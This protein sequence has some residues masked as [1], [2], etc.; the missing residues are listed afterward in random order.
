MLRILC[1]ASIAFFMT[2]TTLFADDP[3]E[4]DGINEGP[5]YIAPDIFARHI[6]AEFDSLY[7]ETRIPEQQHLLRENLIGALRN[8]YEDSPSQTIADLIS[9]SYTLHGNQEQAQLW[10]AASN[11]LAPTQT[12]EDRQT[13]LD[14]L[15]EAAHSEEDQIPEGY[16]MLAAGLG[17]AA[18]E[19]IENRG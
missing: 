15:S 8:I 9:R 6:V 10:Q 12:D 16:W 1:C 17:Y 11:S 19:I 5:S 3:M 7:A 4:E 14:A 18:P 2:S 13:F